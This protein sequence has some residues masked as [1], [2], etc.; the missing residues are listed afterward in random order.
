VISQTVGETFTGGTP[1]VTE[2]GLKVSS[3][4]GAAAVPERICGLVVTERTWWI[5]PLV[6]RT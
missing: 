2:M 4:A 1:R 3:A 6:L 5:T